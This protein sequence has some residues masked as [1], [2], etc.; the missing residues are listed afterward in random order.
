[1]LP[2]LQC[3]VSNT[4]N[5]NKK[6]M[7][8]VQIIKNVE[9][10]FVVLC[11]NCQLLAACLYLSSW[12]LIWACLTCCPNWFLCHWPQYPVWGCTESSSCPIRTVA[13]KYNKI[14]FVLLS[15]NSHLLYL[16]LGKV[17]ISVVLKVADVATVVQWTVTV[18][19]WGVCSHESRLYGRWVVGGFHVRKLDVPHL[20]AVFFLRATKN[21]ICNENFGG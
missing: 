6:L 1:M 2:L 12:H 20:G 17:L 15:K 16:K 10:F 8:S 4:R 21:F 18:F 3:D 19:C 11:K 14:K 5:A 7:H 13:S 9:L